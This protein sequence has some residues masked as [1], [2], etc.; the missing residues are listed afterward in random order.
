M[1]PQ[2][3]WIEWGSW[4][5]RR[6]IS[7]QF[8]WSCWSPPHK[9]VRSTSYFIFNLPKPIWHYAS[10]VNLSEFWILNS[11]LCRIDHMLYLLLQLLPFEQ[12][13]YSFNSSKTLAY[14]SNN[15]MVLTFYYMTCT[16]SMERPNGWSKL[17]SKETKTGI[18]TWIYI[19]I[20]V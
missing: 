11:A 18:L 20:L 5:A 8:L 19:S 14:T 6:C 13:D 10:I 12:K 15:S 1:N 2:P 9:I 7:C 4:R 16:K 17:F 3:L